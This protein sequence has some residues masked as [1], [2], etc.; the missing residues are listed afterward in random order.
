ML[1]IIDDFTL[2]YRAQLVSTCC[3]LI[4][5]TSGHLMCLVSKCLVKF[6]F[7]ITF[8]TLPSFFQN[9]NEVWG[10][11]R[12]G[13]VVRKKK[14]RGGVGYVLSPLNNLAKN[15]RGRAERRWG[16]SRKTVPW[17]FKGCFPSATRLF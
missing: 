6:S 11:V 3:V 13:V 14:R 16:V 4:N 8:L 15:E 10:L 1:L 12:D 2:A 9:Q 17:V 7:F 5:R